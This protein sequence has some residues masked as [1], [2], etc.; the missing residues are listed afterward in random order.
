[1]TQGCYDFNTEDFEKGEDVRCELPASEVAISR[2]ECKYKKEAT[3]IESEDLGGSYCK[4]P[5]HKWSSINKECRYKIDPT[6]LNDHQCRNFAKEAFSAPFKTEQEIKVSYFSFISETFVTG[7]GSPAGGDGA[8]LEGK[9]YNGHNEDLP[10]S[11]QTQ[12]DGPYTARELNTVRKEGIDADQFDNR[13]LENNPKSDDSDEPATKRRL[14]Y[15]APLE[16]TAVELQ[17]GEE[18]EENTRPPTTGKEK[19]V[20]ED[21]KLASTEQFVYPDE[22]K[23]PTGVENNLIP[24]SGIGADLEQNGYHK[25]EFRRKTVGR[26]ALPTGGFYAFKGVFKMM[27]EPRDPTDDSES[28]ESPADASKLPDSAESL[29]QVGEGVRSNPVLAGRASPMAEMKRKMA[30]EELK[31]VASE[32]KKA[33]NLKLPPLHDA[34]PGEG[35]LRKACV[36]PPLQAECFAYIHSSEPPRNTR[37]NPVTGNIAQCLSPRDHAWFRVQC[38]QF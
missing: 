4:R 18:S 29:L 23:L 31:D 24:M 17:E 20:P 35:T 16:G 37:V 36:P 7:E 33:K 28:D 32:W 26:L 10:W 1:M 8:R 11:Y 5:V 38:E 25:K 9:G 3:W 34:G 22:R 2:E 12:D 6:N 30:M 14:L 15:A 19:A 13:V 27:E 21:G